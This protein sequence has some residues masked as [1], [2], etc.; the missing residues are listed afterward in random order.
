MLKRFWPLMFFLLALPA[1]AMGED[2]SL[3]VVPYVIRPGKTERISFSVPEDGSAHLQLT[4]ENGE[5]ITV[6]RE[7]LAVVQ[8]ENHLTWNGIGADGQAVAPGNYYLALSQNGLSARQYLSIGQP[9]PQLLSVQASDAL[10]DDSPWQMTVKTNMAGTLL[11]R[12]KLSDEQWHTII[13]QAVGQGETTV[14]W[15]GVCEGEAIPNGDYAVQ[16]RL[17]D[18]TGYAGT[19]RQSTLTRTHAITPT[20]APTATPKPTPK[21]VIPSAVTTGQQETNYWTLP[22]GEMNEEAIW[23]VM[24]QPMTVIDGNEKDVY[25]LRKN[26]DNSSKAENIVGEITYA[27]QGVHI[28]ETLDN[29]WTLVEAYNSSYGPNC[30][31]RRGYGVT[32][33]L[34]QGYVKTSLLKTIVPRTDYALLIDKLEQKM[35]IFSEGKIIGELLVSTGLNNA[36]QSWNETPAG[37]FVMISKMGGFAAGNLWC[38]YG[39]RINGGCAIHQVPYIGNE[40]T[41]ANRQD[42]SSTAKM[43]GSKASHGC[44]RVQKALNEQGQNMKWLWDNIKKFTKVLIWDDTGRFLEYPDDATPLYYNPNGGKYFHE[45]QNCSSVKNRYLPLSAF[46]YGELDSGEFAKLT[47]CPT[48]AHIQRKAEIDAVNKENGY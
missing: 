13:E 2:L 6:I 10:L 35:Y 47:A 15:D 37:E 7:N 29:G 24:M 42:Y 5:T 30:K 40:S 3:K 14:T 4:D 36:T 38:A 19:A 22:L 9:S 25:R 12:M 17:I 27:S 45:N 34:I 46:T 31:S 48:C 16:V 26:P 33:D 41:P 1:A 28:L 44:V 18:E 32:N 20:P 11:V 39:M 21:L 43:L 23:D 8:G